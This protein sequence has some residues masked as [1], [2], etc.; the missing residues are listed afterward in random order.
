ML[1]R[2]A[3]TA[4]VVVA[5]VP[6]PVSAELPSALRKKIASSA[7]LV[8]DFMSARD[9]EIPQDLL[10]D[11]A[12]VVVMPDMTKGA[13]GVGGR[14]GKGLA[15]CRTA[16]GTWGAPAFLEVGG[17]SIGFQIGGERVDLLLILRGK[18]GAKW[19]FRDKVTLGADASVAA[20]PY[21]RTAGAATDA[22]LR[23][24]ILS[25]SRSAGVF[26]GVALDGAVLKQDRSDNR[27]LY[28][29]RM[30][31]REILMPADPA[32]APTPPPDVAPFLEALERHASA[33]GEAP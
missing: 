7:A 12:C 9:S 5:L 30:T 13:L 33:G 15:S 25:Y 2:F 6:P 14:Y 28:G 3:V 22:A 11:A 4:L 1:A 21:G 24:A 10:R 27:K 16:D 31:S 8:N 18:D 19:L 26:A 29:K 17:A 23:A 20:G 32:D